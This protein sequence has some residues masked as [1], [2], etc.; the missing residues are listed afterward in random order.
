[1]RGDTIAV[2]KKKKRMERVGDGGEAREGV[3]PRGREAGGGGAR[4]VYGRGD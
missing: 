1:M 3:R 2:D 4:Q